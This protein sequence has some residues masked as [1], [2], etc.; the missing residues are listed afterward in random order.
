LEHRSALVRY[1]FQHE[2]EAYVRLQDCQGDVVPKCYGGYSIDFK[3]RELVDDR[4]VNVLL[5]GRIQGTRLNEL[6][7]WE[8]DL[9]KERVYSDLTQIMNKLNCRGVL[10]PQLR[11][12]QLIVDRHSR[13][14][15][16]TNFLYWNEGGKDLK[17][18]L[19]QQAESVKMLLY[20]LGYS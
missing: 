10:L 11:A 5:L 3:D 9:E 1:L 4:I 8:T 20:N 16:M 12:D 19:L 6:P 2:L 13:R 7:L 14:L 17:G 15:Y 18:N